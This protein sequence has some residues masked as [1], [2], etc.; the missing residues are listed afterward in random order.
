[1]PLI[2]DIDDFLTDVSRVDI[3]TDLLVR[4]AVPC[5]T[6]ISMLI[7][8]LDGDYE[9]QI[10]QDGL[11][12]AL[13]SRIYGLGFGYGILSVSN[14]MDIAHDFLTG[15]SDVGG[16]TV[17]LRGEIIAPTGDL[18]RF[19]DGREIRIPDRSD[20]LVTPRTT[21]FLTDASRIDIQFTRIDTR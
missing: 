7:R 4:A 18:L 17:T 19:T 16:T 2:S 13:I 1:M 6:N 10:D 14:V 5:V 21:V 15:R 12:E 8:L 3:G 20:L 9:D 11:K